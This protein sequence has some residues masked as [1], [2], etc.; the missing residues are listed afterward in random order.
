[1]KVRRKCGKKNQRYRRGVITS[2]VYDDVSRSTGFAQALRYQFAHGAAEELQVGCAFDPL[3][4][5]AICRDRRCIMHTVTREHT[6]CS[7]G[8]NFRGSGGHRVCWNCSGNQ[9]SPVS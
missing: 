3:P 9:V 1:M 2:D 4:K 8:Q 6:L 5:M 7:T